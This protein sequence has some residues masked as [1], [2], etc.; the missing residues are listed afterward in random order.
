MHDF[1]VGKSVS[2]SQNLLTGSTAVL[3]ETLFYKT[4]VV[5]NTD[6]NI[7]ELNSSDFLELFFY[8]NQIWRK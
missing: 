1:G 8:E 7:L 5:Q 2:N 6:L 3:L 4:E